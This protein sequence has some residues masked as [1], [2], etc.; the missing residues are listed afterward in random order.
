MWLTSCRKGVG[1]N[2]VGGKRWDWVCVDRG[3]GC[4]ALVC[5]GSEVS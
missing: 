2:E 1:L 5:E 3:S 4:K